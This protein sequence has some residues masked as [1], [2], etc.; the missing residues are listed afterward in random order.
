M[1]KTIEKKG[2][3]ADLTRSLVNAG[4]SGELEG[5]KSIS[6][7]DTHHL[8]QAF[9]P[10]LSFL[11]ER[12]DTIKKTKE[13]TAIVAKRGHLTTF[14]I[15]ETR[16]MTNANAM[17]RAMQGLIKGA[18]GKA[19]FV[20]KDGVLHVYASPFHEKIEEAIYTGT[21]PKLFTPTRRTVQLLDAINSPSLRKT[22]SSTE[23]KRKSLL[24]LHERSATD[25]MRKLSPSDFDIKISPLGVVFASKK[26][27]A[28]EKSQ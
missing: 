26:K 27:G 22:G 14:S 7:H 18:G 15:G 24:A 12:S 28:E 6:F 13:S 10:S 17:L 3:R 4:H 11:D 2:V 23:E 16:G 1:K 21:A 8:N 20:V 5:I 19:H 25:L 9:F